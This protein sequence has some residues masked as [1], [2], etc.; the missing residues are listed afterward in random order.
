MHGH[1]AVVH[2]LLAVGAAWQVS[3]AT[4]RF[5]WQQLMATHAV[6]QMLLDDAC[7]GVHAAGGP[8]GRTV[9]FGASKRCKCKRASP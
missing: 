4:Q 6:V 9:L 3:L 8:A 2:A 1:E 7:V 5:L